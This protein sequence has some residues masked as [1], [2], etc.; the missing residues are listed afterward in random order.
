LTIISSASVSI[1]EYTDKGIRHRTKRKNKLGKTL[2]I[3]K[4]NKNPYLGFQAK[5]RSPLLT[6]HHL[7]FIIWLRVR[8]CIINFGK[9]F[10][11]GG[12]AKRDKFKGISWDERSK[13]RKMM[14][15]FSLVLFEACSGHIAKIPNMA[16][17]KLRP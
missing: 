11:K 16:R 3:Q 2:Y 9:E 13:I 14:K 17:I 12:P 5:Y 15:G 8:C 7:S 10:L 6:G 4:S 1:W